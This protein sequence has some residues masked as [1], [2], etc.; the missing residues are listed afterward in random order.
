MWASGSW[1]QPADEPLALI[2]AELADDRQAYRSRALAEANSQGWWRWSIAAR[3]A[4]RSLVEV[5]SQLG[6]SPTGRARLGVAILGIEE[7]VRR[8]AEGRA[9][10]PPEF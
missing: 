3:A 9:S 6:F 1:L 2:A 8:L 5:L 7:G 10:E 4:E